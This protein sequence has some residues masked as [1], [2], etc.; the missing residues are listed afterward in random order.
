MRGDQFDR[1]PNLPVNSAIAIARSSVGPG[2]LPALFGQFASAIGENYQC[3]LLGFF[4]F[5][6]LMEIEFDIVSSKN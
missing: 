1:E 3:V 5:A 4:W 2:R 6:K